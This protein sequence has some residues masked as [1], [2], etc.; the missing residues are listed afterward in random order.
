MCRGTGVLCTLPYYGVFM[1]KCASHTSGFSVL[2]IM[3]FGSKKECET[4]CE[5]VKVGHRVRNERPVELKLLTV[6]HICEPIA[7]AA[8]DLSNYPYLQTLNFAIDL[9]C[10]SLVS[11]DTLVGSD[12]YWNLLTGEIIKIETGPVAL[13]DGYCRA[14]Q[15]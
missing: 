1:Q 13:L 5:V 15:W 6:D 8:I 4:N 10:S 14:L 3:T 9:E 12:Q 2:S 11:P 7:N